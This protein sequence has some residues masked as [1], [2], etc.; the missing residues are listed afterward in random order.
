VIPSTPRARGP[1][2]RGP[3]VALLGA[4]AVAGAAVAALA[5]EEP[6]DRSRLDD[7]DMGMLQRSLLK[8]YVCGK[9]STVHELKLDEIKLALQMEGNPSRPKIA[10]PTQEQL[11]VMEERHKHIFNYMLAEKTNAVQMIHII[12]RILGQETHLTGEGRTERAILEKKVEMIEIPR[13][14]GKGTEIREAGK[15]ISEVLGCPVQV[16]TIDTEIYR[17]WFTMGPTTG[18]AIIKQVCASIPFDYRI[19]KGVL[20]FRHHD[21]GKNAPKIG[22]DDEEKKALED[23]KKKKQ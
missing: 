21:L 18:E 22:L 15:M 10:N 12:D 16:E 17:I 13:G 2:P 1:R 9:E 3:A 23:E 19:E 14:A 4:A 20:I 6:A 7:M 5:L 8:I 11:Q